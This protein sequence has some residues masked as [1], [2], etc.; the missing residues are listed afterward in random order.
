[1]FSRVEEERLEY[2]R[3]S[4]LFQLNRLEEQREEAAFFLD[5]DLEV[6]HSDAVTLPSSFLGSWAWASD[7]VA[8][9]LALCREHGKPSLFITIT[10]NARWP[11]I[12]SRLSPGQSASDI[13][14]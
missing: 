8:D 2:I 10:T 13:P 9:A 11:E 5:P 6:Q 7:Q 1:M 4:C 12:I 14:V 3:A